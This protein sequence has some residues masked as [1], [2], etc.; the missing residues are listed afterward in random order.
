MLSPAYRVVACTQCGRDTHATPAGDADVAA[1]TLQLP[2]GGIGENIREMQLA[3]STL[4]PLLRAKE[5]GE[6]PTADRL[7]S[8]SQSSRRL[9]HIWDQLIICDGV[10]C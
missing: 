4:R 8:A 7:G 1:T 6:R 3:D 9:L 5:L 2:T 10:L